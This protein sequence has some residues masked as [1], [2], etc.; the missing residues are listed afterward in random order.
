VTP[1]QA[2]GHDGPAA[3]AALGKP[4]ALDS[5]RATWPGIP[6][7]IQSVK[8]DYWRAMHLTGLQSLEGGGVLTI[9]STLNIDGGW[10]GFDRPGPLWCQ[11]VVFFIMVPYLIGVG[12]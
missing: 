5:L 12:S 10:W 9:A 2:P 11:G 4:R 7:C 3:K 8:V 1:E 6:E